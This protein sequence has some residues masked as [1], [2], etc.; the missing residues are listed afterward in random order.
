M[1]LVYVDVGIV[2]LGE[3]VY[4]VQGGDIPIHGEHSVSDDDP[5]PGLLGGLQVLL[6]VL[7]V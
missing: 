4:S 6:Q 5:L 1:A 2:F 7:H 3:L